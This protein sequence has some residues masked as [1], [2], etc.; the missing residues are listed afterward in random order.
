MTALTALQ[1]QQIAAALHGPGFW[2][3]R[4]PHRSR[5][6]ATLRLERVLATRAREVARSMAELPIDQ[7]VDLLQATAP[8]LTADDLRGAGLGA[9]ADLIGTS[10]RDGR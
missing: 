2:E 1:I 3:K 7:A 5:K 10:A 6:T 9:I 4:K 8:D